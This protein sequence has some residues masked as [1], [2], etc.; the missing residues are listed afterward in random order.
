MSFDF[1][2][3][4]TEHQQ[5]LYG[6]IYSLVANSTVSWDIL[7][8]TNIILWK[9]QSEF[10]PGSNFEAWA[11]TVAHFQVLAFLRDRQRDPMTLLTPELLEALRD[12]AAAIADR[13]GERLRILQR[14]REDL[15]GKAR[16]LITLH[17]EQGLSMKTVAI[18][19]GMSLSA[20]KQS[21]FRVRR[22]LRD[23]IQ[24]K[25]ASQPE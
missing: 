15:A 13:F 18:Q 2:R 25:L 22:T 23:C 1:S 9:K 11:R 7:Q 16:E 5:R 12:D 4:I 8:E 6:Y 21:I 20:V 24:T 17:Y 19:L 10:Q 14:C 3:K